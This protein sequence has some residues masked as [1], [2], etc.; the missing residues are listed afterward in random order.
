MIGLSAPRHYLLGIAIAYLYDCIMKNWIV[1][2]LPILSCV[3]VD[4][5]E[6]ELLPERMLISSYPAKLQVGDT[7]QLDAIFFDSIGQPSRIDFQWTS[8]NEEVAIVLESGEL[9]GLSRGEVEISVVHPN[10]PNLLDMVSVEVSAEETIVS[11]GVRQGTLQGIGGYD[12]SGEFLMYQDSLTSELVLEIIGAEIDN[13]APGP[14]YYLSNQTR[15]VSGGISFGVAPDGD[16]RYVLP[17]SLSL[18]SYDVLVVWCEPF[19]VSLG[20]GEFEN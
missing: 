5:L 7:F 8:S 1:L 15:A 16:S 19:G 3:G 9:I 2:L 18:Q 6:I 13:T 17:D 4:V 11:D 20:Y 10:K 12:I 14:Y